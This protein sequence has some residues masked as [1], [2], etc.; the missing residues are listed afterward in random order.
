[1]SGKPE[2]LVGPCQVYVF[3]KGFAGSQQSLEG[4]GGREKGG[5]ADACFVSLGPRHLV[6]I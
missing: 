4:M 1:M 3:T 2:S 6:D 5:F